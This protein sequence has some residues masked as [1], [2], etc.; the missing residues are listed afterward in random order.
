MK[1]DADGWQRLDVRMLVIGPAEALRQFAVPLIVGVIGVRSSQSGLPPWTTPLMILAPLLIGLIPWL[2]TRYRIADQ[3]FE[4]RTGLL[5]RKH[6]TA[7]LDRIRSVDLEA[8]LLHRLLGLSKV[9]IG[10]GV[11]ETRIELKAVTGTGARELRGFLLAR[12]GTVVSGAATPTGDASAAL[13]AAY[14]EP[15]VLAR[16]DWSWLRFAPLSLSRLAIVAG[17]FGAL[18]QWG[19]DLPIFDRDH[20]DS[21][22]QWAQGFAVSLVIVSIVVAAAAGWI[23]VSVL[24]YVISWWNLRLTRQDRTIHLTAGLFT[25]RSISVEEARVRGVEL[26]EPLLL[27]LARGGELSTLATGVGSGG[28]TQVLPPS[29]V[30]VCQQVGEAVLG[31][32]RPL[33]GAL[34][35][36]GP[37]ARR[38]CHV[39]AQRTSLVITA[40]VAGVSYVADWSWWLP[41]GVAVALVSTALL[42]AEAAYR[43]LGHLLT[44]DHLT[45]GSGALDR[46][47]TVLERDGVIGWVIAQ[48]FFQRRS[49]LATLVATTAAGAEA[50]AVRDIPLG[51]A[52]Q[53][54]AET[55]PRAVHA[56]L[57]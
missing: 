31:T 10:T 42:T 23:A 28:V 9:T 12:G 25:T 13:P 1:T 15:E 57:A 32:S 53:I 29:P 19:D 33:L 5:N 47:R 38:R 2:T 44:D 41:A 27:R 3:Q 46:R 14:V 36:H 34:T 55:T 43:N 6:L 50:V 21:A 37:A 24:G 45:S 40:V 49:G 35:P 17:A 51:Q 48:S 26:T 52:I 30:A 20:L 18:S 11:D 16:I 54:A 39:R 4:L 22:W 56:F 8:S 7:P